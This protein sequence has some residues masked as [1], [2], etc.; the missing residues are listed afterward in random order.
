M[1]PFW[2][3]LGIKIGKTVYRIAL[4]NLHYE[5]I[6]NTLLWDRG[7][8]KLVWKIYITKITF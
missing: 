2:I 7:W 3:N 5:S 6:N 1:R 4:L 8:K